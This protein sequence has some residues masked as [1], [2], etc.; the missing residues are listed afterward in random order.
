MPAWAQYWLREEGLPRVFRL[1]ELSEE[2]VF[3]FNLFCNIFLLERKGLVHVNF[4]PQRPA[5]QEITLEPTELAKETR[6]RAPLPP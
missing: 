4:N 6:R 1:E 3:Q 5:G 2:Q